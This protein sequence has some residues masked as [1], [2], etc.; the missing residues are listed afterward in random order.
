VLCTR[1]TV[2]GRLGLERRGAMTRL[3]VVPAQ[4]LHRVP[5]GVSLE[6]AAVSEPS[7]V[8]LGAVRAAALEPGDPLVILG[9][10]PIGLLALQ[11]ARAAG[12][13][14]IVVVGHDSDVH[15]L[16]TARHL[17]A[18]EALAGDPAS[19]M[20]RVMTLTDGAGV[21][22]VIDASGAVS[23]ATLGLAMVSKGGRLVLV[24]IYPEALPIDATRDVVRQMKSIHGAYGGASLDFDRVLALMADGRLDVRSLVSELPLRDAVHGFELLRRKQAFKILLRPEA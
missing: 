4:C 7:A 9:P 8:A 13:G 24:G 16:D 2:E 22:A 19:V 6:S 20:A 15:R 12:A 1:R 23:A 14:P 17:G 18:R 21:P 3:A 10:G 5:D 11:L